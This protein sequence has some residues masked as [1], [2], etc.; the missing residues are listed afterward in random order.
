MQEGNVHYYQNPELQ[1]L[2]NAYTKLHSEPL[3]LIPSHVHIVENKN[4]FDE[5]TN[6]AQSILQR[7]ENGVPYGQIAVSTRHPEA[8]SMLIEAVFSHYHI[9][10]FIDAR[11][12]IQSN[13]LIISILAIL[14]FYSR[15][16]RQE[17]VL[18]FL[19]AG[20]YFDHPGE[21]D[22]VENEILANK[23]QGMKRFGKAKHSE[24]V[25]FY[26]FFLNLFKQLKEAKNVGRFVDVLLNSI[27]QL[28]FPN[29][30]HRISDSF[31]NQGL[32]ERSDLYNRLWS[33]VESF[34]D[35]LKV[36]MGDLPVQTVLEGC[37]TVHRL[38][39]VC[40]STY[41]TG[42]LPQNPDAVQITSIDRS[43]VTDVNT[44][45]LIGVVE[46][47]FPASLND[48]GILNDLE[49]SWLNDH[50]VELADDSLTKTS[51]ERFLIYTT[52]FAPSEQ[53]YVSYAL[54]DF[55]GG[56]CVPASAV[57]GQMK[58]LC[59]NITVSKG[60][61]DRET[62]IRIPTEVFI[63]AVQAKALFLPEKIPLSSV[64]KLERYRLCPYNYF[65]SYGL[66]LQEREEGQLE[67][68]D[69]GNI[70]HKL[71]EEGS[72]VLTTGDKTSREIVEDIF[73]NALISAQ[74]IPEAVESG[75]G[76][77]LME[78]LKKFAI[79]T[80]D[81]IKDQLDA[82][83]FSPVG[84]EV[85]FGDGQPDS[86][87]PLMVKIGADDLPAIRLQ[88]KIDRFDACVD[89][90]NAY[91]R[92]IDYKSSAKPLI[93]EDIYAGK[94][95]Q[96]IAYM[97]ALLQQETSRKKLAEMLNVPADQTFLPAGVLYFLIKDDL[98]KIDSSGTYKKNTYCMDG[99]VLNDDTVLNHMIGN[100]SAEVIS[101]SRKT[102]GNFKKKN[103]WI[104]F[105]DYTQL[106]EGVDHAV[107]TTVYEIISGKIAPY[108]QH[109]YQSSMPCTYCAYN[110]V[111]GAVLKE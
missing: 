78:R 104:S 98:E 68:S 85:A 32:L 54:K 100:E 30:M 1:F 5:I 46:G 14:R 3:D 8:Y 28:D 107:R 53:L 94:R 62:E 97:K 38:L 59:P 67:L 12:N 22:D 66:C 76:H 40:F 50:A 93:F 83:D 75:R 89:S 58:R 79:S 13:P 70:M 72:A 95:L 74:I 52:L 37:E 47:A 45:Y 65:L 96:L 11:Q 27:E 17:D 51:K 105:A 90:P 88:G 29:K 84:F 49:R 61:P 71:I 60:V 25:R 99:L 82:G 34:C 42:F 39:S 43:R 18:T 73:P 36:F 63:E 4:V 106:S 109:P 19:K 80:L 108:P 2:E 103:N 26:T 86:F 56:D 6:V 102:D 87:P 57:V 101:F 24:I 31:R 110:S 33:Q 92:I 55:A 20:L 23:I 81:G 9:P 44:L 41:Q 16:F 91:I 111:C 10:Y 69:I 35:Q 77:V 15:N 21:G 7:R 48:E 64:S